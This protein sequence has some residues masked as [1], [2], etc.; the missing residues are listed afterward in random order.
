MCGFVEEL[1]VPEQLHLLIDRAV[2]TALTLREPSVLIV[3]HD[4]LRMTMRREELRAHGVMH[5]SP[6][7]APGRILPASEAVR[8]AADLSNTAERVAVLIGQG[9]RG[10]ADE[11]VRVAEMLEAGVSC[12]LLGKPV[13][14]ESLP[15]H[16]GVVGHLGTTASE[17]LMRHC[18]ALLM[19][20]TNEPYT[21]FLPF[22]GQ[23]RAVQI[24]IDGRNLGLRYPTE[25]N[26]VGDA[27]ETLRALLP[28]LVQKPASSWGPSVVEAIRGRE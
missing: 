7:M 23:A 19:I 24:D 12:A 8:S 13:L 1:L 21:E 10:A 14:D 2:R 6:G 5:S 26:I 11:V 3:P 16:A 28:L 18:D 20:G 15:Y 9:A 27:R 25:V 22:P 4:V 17:Y